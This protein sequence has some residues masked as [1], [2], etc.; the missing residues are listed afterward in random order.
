MTFTAGETKKYIDIFAHVLL[1]LI[2][3][4]A[5]FSEVDFLLSTL[6]TQ[7]VTETSVGLLIGII[8]IWRIISSLY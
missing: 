3:F 4:C 7:A 5:C 8:G 6:V 2:Y 1:H